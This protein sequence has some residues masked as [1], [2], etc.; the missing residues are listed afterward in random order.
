VIEL[1]LDE[2]AELCSGSLERAAGA[3]RVTGLE[4]DSRRVR[5][6]DLFVAIRGG[7]AFAGDALARGADAVLVPDDPHAAM[8]ALGR[9]VR[10][11]TNARVIGI[12]GATGK[13]STKDILAS[14]L[15][16]HLRTVCSEQSHNNEIGLPLTITR[17]TEETEA[18]VAE[19]GSRGLGQIAELCS[20]ARPGI[21]VIAQLGPAHLELFGTLENVAAAEAEIVGCLPPGGAVVAPAG[22]RLLEPYLTRDDV[23]IVTYGDGGDVRLE[24]F[25]ADEHSHVTVVA[26]EE[27]VELEFNFRSRHN[28]TNALAALGAYLALGLPLREAQAGALDISL[29]RWREEETALRDGGLLINDSYNANPVSMTAALEHLAERS[30]GRRRVAVLGDMAELGPEAPGYH[31]QVGAA[32]DRAGVDVLIA[33]GDLARGYL[34]GAERIR[35]QR[36]APGP[37]EALECLDDV[38]EP[39]D[40]ILVKGSRSAG[41]EEIAAALAGNTGAS[42]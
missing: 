27:R 42:A 37:R 5:P 2:V 14:L 15:R 41:L 29:S 16:P 1:T 32:A 3:T 9:V 33:V 13:T 18:I 7:A 31:G 23:S 28:A 6:G 22:E 10:E 11:R 34:D 21:A 36:W 26:L 19:M 24:S 40:C 8:A 4:I 38:I 39:G 12:T 17:A 25:A 35:V 20:I 30:R